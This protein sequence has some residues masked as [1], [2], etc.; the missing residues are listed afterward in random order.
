MTSVD[1]APK[2]PLA[3]RAFI[4]LASAFEKTGKAPKEMPQL[5]VESGRLTERLKSDPFY[6]GFADGFWRGPGTAMLNYN[7]DGVAKFKH[8]Y[9]MGRAFSDSYDKRIVR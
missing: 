5:Q 4:I 8:G 3:E 1:I 9:G 2:A 7:S 6:V